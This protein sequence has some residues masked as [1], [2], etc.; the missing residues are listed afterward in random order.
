MITTWF[1]F[2]HAAAVCLWAAGLICFPFLIRQ[3][4]DAGTMTDLHRLHSMARFFFVVL[5]SPAAF[6][7]IGSGI[8]LIFLRQTFVE[9]FSLK[10]LCVGLL[11]II[12]LLTGRII[13]RSFEVEATITT[14]H[15]PAMTTATVIVVT[16]IMALVLAKPHID[17]GVTDLFAPGR[18]RTAAAHASIAII[19]HQADPVIE[20]QLAAMPTGQASE[21]GGQYGKCEPMR[22][23]FLGS[24]ES[25]AP[26]SARDRQ[27]HHR[28]DGVRPTTDTAT[29]PFDGQQLR[30]TDEGCEHAETERESR[31][32]EPRAQEERIALRPVQHVA[33]ERGEY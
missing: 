22:Q 1:K 17:S 8:A 30:S 7:A 5:L 14:W 31:A 32:P 15:Y 10:L 6:I 9:W 20:H 2:V 33:A 29:N 12:H 26:I 24:R 23:H 25:H 3:R 13:L 21:N 28:R 27:Q 18:L 11:T 19:D 4:N 16:T